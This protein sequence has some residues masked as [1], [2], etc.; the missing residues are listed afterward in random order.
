MWTKFPSQYLGMSSLPMRVLYSPYVASFQNQNASKAAGGGLKN[1]AEFNI[2]LPCKIL[3][4]Y[5][6]AK[7]P[8]EF[9]AL[10]PGPNDGTVL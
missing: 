10:R 8:S 1:D 3:G 9:F 4:E 7:S 2:F 5:V 6:H